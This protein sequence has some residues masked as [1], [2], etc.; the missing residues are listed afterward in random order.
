MTG[1]AAVDPTKTEGMKLP[2]RDWIVLPTLGLL[3]FC[4]I[5]GST[6]SIAR[7][8]FSYSDKGLKDCTVFNDPST[9]PRGIP[10]CV[11]WDKGYETQPIEYRLN[12]S[13]YRA[14]TDFGP[15]APG[16]YRIVTVGSSFAMAYG[17][18][19][20]MSYAA[21]LPG[22]LT[23]LTRRK[24][25]LLNEGFAGGGG[26]NLRLDK[27]LAFNPDMILWILTPW[28]IG[29][30]FATVHHP[31]RANRHKPFL[32]R[33]WARINLDFATSF[34]KAIQETFSDTRTALMLRHY[35]FESQSQ[36]IKSFLRAGD[37]E[38][39]FLKAEPSAEWKESLRQFSTAV[40]EYEA[41]AEAAG[42]PLVA[43]L[44]P[45]RA[46]AAMISRGEWPAGYDPYK[47]N[48]ELRSI[49]SSHGGIY[50]DILPRFRA[51]PN[52]ERYYLPVDGHLDAAGNAILSN[53]LAKEL[54]SGAVP[55]LDVSR[56]PHLTMAR[57]R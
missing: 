7:L 45:D 3:T 9:G 36:Y 53:L 20:K 10:N 52:P 25:D 14:D 8:I 4:L 43:V 19:N 49:L 42:V 46:Q 47:L 16:T 5:I 17:A 29:Q 24:V 31:P 18:D 51:I 50:I 23:S 15:K 6:E 26:V 22:E 34:T 1:M 35:L 44:V 30:E 55:A 12:S 21:L 32:R 27:A 28:D 57:G 13:G 54:T 33:A 40:P 38:A 2:R 56:Q 39:G 41:Q 11:C 48:N 37:K